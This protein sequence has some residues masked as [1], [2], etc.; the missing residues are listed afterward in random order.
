MRI[1]WAFWIV[2]SLTI[3]SRVFL[4]I[5]FPLYA[6]GD[7]LIALRASDDAIRTN[8]PIVITHLY[9]LLWHSLVKP[10]Y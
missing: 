2:A 7:E 6:F 8:L 1:A 5:A 9:V 4:G 10:L 3:S